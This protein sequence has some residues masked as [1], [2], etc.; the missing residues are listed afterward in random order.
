MPSVLYASA[1]FATS[2]TRIRV[3]VLD[4]TLE[5]DKRAPQL[6]G[7]EARLFAKDKFRTG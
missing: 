1:D 4:G 6:I 7:G 3:R 2:D 5:A